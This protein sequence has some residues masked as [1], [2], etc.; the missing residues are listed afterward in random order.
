MDNVIQRYLRKLRNKSTVKRVHIDRNVTLN[1]EPFQM[2]LIAVLSGWCHFSNLVWFDI[3]KHL[4]CFTILHEI[5]VRC[6]IRGPCCNFP[7]RVSLQSWFLIF[8][9]ISVSGFLLHQYNSSIMFNCF[10]A[11]SPILPGAFHNSA[12]KTH[13]PFEVRNSF[14]VLRCVIAFRWYAEPNVPKDFSGDVQ[15]GLLGPINRGFTSIRHGSWFQWSNITLQEILLITYDIVCREPAHKIQ[16]EYCLLCP[17]P[18][19]RD[20]DHL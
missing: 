7:T 12:A 1:S 4:F 6:W 5:R 11:F 2:G 17:L 16:K 20:C 9:F 3:S 8:Y 15:G 19:P 14:L 18:P 13:V 10:F